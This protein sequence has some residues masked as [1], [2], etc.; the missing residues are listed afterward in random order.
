M[1]PPSSLAENHHLGGTGPPKPVESAFPAVPSLLKVRKTVKLKN[2]S[3]VA[4]D[5]KRLAKFFLK[6][7]GNRAALSN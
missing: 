5:G 6:P 3:L 4:L 7:C 1:I 2:V